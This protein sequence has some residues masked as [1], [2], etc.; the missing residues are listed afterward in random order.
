MIRRRR[1]IMMVGGAMRIMMEG[2]MGITMVWV[3]ELIY[4]YVCFFV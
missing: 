3:I 2:G 1:I 4:L